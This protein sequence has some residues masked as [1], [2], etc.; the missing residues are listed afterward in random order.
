MRAAV[1]SPA[2]LRDARLAA[3]VAR[4]RYVDADEPGF[5]RVRR[6]AGFRYL[7]PDKREL[8]APKALGR[9]AKLAIPPAWRNVWIC[10]S[11]NGHVQ[12]TGVDAR[13]RKQYRY[14]AAWRA[15]RDEAKFHDIIAFGHALPS[16]RAK[17]A[18]DLRQP[19]L[20]K[21]KVL[22]TIVSLMQRTAI[23]VG[24]DEYAASN[25]SYGL[26]TLL[27]RHARVSPTQVEFRFRGKGGKPHSVK[28][29]D[30]KL[31]AIVKRCRDIPGQRL[32][33]YQTSSG[34]YRSVTSSDVNRYL[35]E[36]TGA[37]FTAK[38]F[39]TWAG[40]V[41]AVLE[42]AK[43]EASAHATLRAAKSALSKAILSVANH[44]GNTPN[45]CR[46]CYIHPAVLEAH[47][48]NDLKKS[49]ESQLLHSRRRSG[50]S[51]EEAAVLSCLERWA[52]REKAIGRAA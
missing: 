5:T 31:A 50:L 39:R 25:G 33:Q 30:R 24:N 43:A 29:S 6:G 42:L 4:L 47:G 1:N 26:T 46:K 14:H 11:E 48:R 21:Q 52:A 19:R 8:R 10:Q 49:F 13:G 3:R 12:A 38:E 22:A 34:R 15:T 20:S 51:R 17:V 36:L 7:T 27:D 23:R 35:R 2:L 28:L 45:I 18:R 37:P 40:T 41:K 32:F 44:L 9:I 16:L